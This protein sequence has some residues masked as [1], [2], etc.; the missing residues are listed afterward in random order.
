MGFYDDVYSS[1]EKHGLTPIGEVE[2]T[3]PDYS[4]DFAAVWYHKESGKFYFGS[5]ASCSCP[6]PFEGI[7][8]LDQLESGTWWDAAK[9]LVD[10]L[11]EMDA[12]G[13]RNVNRDKIENE[14][15]TVIVAMREV[16]NNGN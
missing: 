16:N 14:I 6:S 13:W 7:T 15:A 12:D 5:D 1:P 11:D 3:E 8:K 2:W 9:Y 4:F 10:T